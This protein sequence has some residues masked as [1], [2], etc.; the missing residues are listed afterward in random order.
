MISIGYSSQRL[1]FFMSLKVRKLG[2]KFERVIKNASQS[3]TFIKLSNYLLLVVI[4][5]INML[6]Y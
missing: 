1:S 2:L 5:F 3:K 6:R 4:N